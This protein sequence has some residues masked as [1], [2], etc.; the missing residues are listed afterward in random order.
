MTQAKAETKK[1]TH[2]PSEAPDTFGEQK[3]TPTVTIE[4]DGGDTF[5]AVFRTDEDAQT[6]VQNLNTMNR[7]F[8]SVQNEDG[9]RKLFGLEYVKSVEITGVANPPEK[10]KRVAVVGEVVPLTGSNLQSARWG[11]GDTAQVTFA[12]GS[13]WEYSGVDNAA[14][15]EFINAENAGKHYDKAI[16]SKFAER[17]LP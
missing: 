17:R 7:R 6:F 14:F 2:F 4:L 11:E 12:D 10:Q 9:E 15:T 8:I 1:P 13:M 3:D 16:R 5:D